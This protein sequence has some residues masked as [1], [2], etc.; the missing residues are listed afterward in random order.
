MTIYLIQCTKKKKKYKCK[1]EEL[2][3]ES[4]WF[5]KALA[6]AKKQ[7]P[8]LIFILSAKYHL[9]RLNDIVEPYNLTLKDFSE[10]EKKVW[11]YIVYKKIKKVNPTKI[12]FLAGV[13]YR[14]Y[15][16]YKLRQQNIECFCP[17][18]NLSIGYQLQWL[19]D[20]A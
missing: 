10:K 1:A 8:D 12:I 3:S 15:L 2:Y 11:S 14:K 9:V 5:E 13:A 7:N 17:L 18:K 4:D 6:Y 20:N 19:K 16:I